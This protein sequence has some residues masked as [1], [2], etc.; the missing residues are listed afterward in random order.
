ME[1]FALIIQNLKNHRKLVA[2]IYRNNTV[3]IDK[4]KTKRR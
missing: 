4:S 1:I 3:S 2:K